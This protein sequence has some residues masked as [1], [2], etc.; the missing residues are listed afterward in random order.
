MGEGISVDPA[1]NLYTVDATV[2]THS[3]PLRGGE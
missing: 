3:P 2:L 1:G